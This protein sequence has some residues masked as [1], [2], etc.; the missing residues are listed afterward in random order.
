M[1]NAIETANEIKRI[2]DDDPTILESEHIHVF[3]DKKGF[4]FFKKEEIHLDGSVHHATDKRKAEDVA[5]HY[6][7]GRELISGIT[8]VH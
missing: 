3:A 5:R 2:I 1:L 6:G 4:L 7:G 8:V